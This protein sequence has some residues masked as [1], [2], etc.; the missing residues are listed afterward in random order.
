M[1]GAE[2]VVRGLHAHMTAH[3]P[4][5]LAGL[6]ARL[7]ATSVDLPEIKRIYPDEVDVLS[8]EK[9]PSLVIT[10]PDTDG[11]L[12]NRQTDLTSTYEEYSYR[13]NIRLFVYV[14]AADS[15]ATSRLIKRMTLGVREALLTKKILPVGE[16][17]RAEIDPQ[18]IKESYS[19]VEKGKRGFIAASYIELQVVSLEVLEGLN[20][21]EIPAEI[22]TGFGSAGGDAPITLPTDPAAARH[23]I[24]DE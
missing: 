15:M 8:I 4:T 10:T 3:V 1:L 16:T 22:S 21:P 24:F 2:G 11:K 20:V 6:R 7:K 13:Y 23:P 14:I 12:T 19:E 17:D 18:T 9:F 5:R